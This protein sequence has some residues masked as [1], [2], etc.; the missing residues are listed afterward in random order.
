MIGGLPKWVWDL[1]ADLIDYEAEHGKDA[2]CLAVALNRAPADI[3]ESATA[4]AEYRRG[5]PVE[6]APPQR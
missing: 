6:P 2:G 3:R 4:I 5:L 1:L